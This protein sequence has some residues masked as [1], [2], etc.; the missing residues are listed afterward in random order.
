MASASVISAAEMIRE[1]FR[2]DSVFF[3]GPMQTSSSANFTWSESL[4]TSEWTAT[5]RTPSSLQAQ[6]MRSAISPRF[7]IRIFLNMDG[8]RRRSADRADLE[9]DLAVLDGLG[10]RGEDLH[11]LA[12][13]LRLDLVHELHRLDDT[14]RLAL[15]HAAPDLD[16]GRRLGR[17]GAIEGPD[18]RG[19]HRDEAV[20]GLGRGRRAAGLR[21][22][23]DLRG[24]RGRRR[25]G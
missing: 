10:V 13:H 16:E 11:D 21:G 4:S 7:A 8:A 1:M 6:M 23:R 14:Q 24:V 25:V 9:E 5:V 17:G 15:A 3:A 20:G 12:L 19:D 22:S 18:H 2:Y